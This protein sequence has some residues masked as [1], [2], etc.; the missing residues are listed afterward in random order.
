MSRI[1][2]IAIHV[3][4]CLK[5]M[6][7]S[8]LNN[9]F[10]TKHLSYSMRNPNKLTKPKRRT[11]NFGIRSLS[12]LG[13]KVWNDLPFSCNDLNPINVNDF[14]VLLNT[15]NGPDFSISSCPYL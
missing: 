10:E 11:T 6:N 7:P 12:Y 14:T 2:C 8:P 3:F 9:M 5:D 13:S 4:K 15:W 1:Y